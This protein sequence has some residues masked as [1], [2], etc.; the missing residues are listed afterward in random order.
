M[1]EQYVK[2]VKVKGVII[3]VIDKFNY[4]VHVADLDQDVHTRIS[5]KLYM[6]HSQLLVVGAEMIIEV[7]LDDP[8]RG[9]FFK[10]SPDL[11]GY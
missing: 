1:P 10:R 7:R 2:P 3:E 8:S 5:A 9:R 6:N 11:F 4:L